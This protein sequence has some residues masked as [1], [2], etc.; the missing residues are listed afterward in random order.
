MPPGIRPI[1]KQ[2]RIEVLSWGL[3]HLKYWSGKPVL[4]PRVEI[5]CGGYVL[6]L[7]DIK[8]VINNP[9]FPKTAHFFDVS[10]PQENNY[11]PPINIRLLDKRTNGFTPLVGKY[12]IKDFKSYD[13]DLIVETLMK[14]KGREEEEDKDSNK[15]SL[16]S[17]FEE[18][19]NLSIAETVIIIFFI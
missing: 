5:E 17:E 2:A 11:K 7:P 6:M 9:N 14:R 18:E 15:N 13:P 3:R 4:N 8:N 12:V 16:M 10:L 1:L 19:D